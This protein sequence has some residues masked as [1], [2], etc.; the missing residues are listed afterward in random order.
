MK[1]HQQGARGV[2]HIGD[3]RAGQVPNQPRVNVAECQ[4]P[5]FGFG[6]RAF[7]IIKDPFYFRARK[8]SGKRQACFFAQTILSAVFCQLI[9]NHIGAGV[10]P[11][12]CIVD[13]LA[14]GF[15]PDNR[16]LALICNSNRDDITNFRLL[17]FD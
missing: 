1:I 2:G 15:I 6:A 16:R 3:M 5:F 9:A 13:R 7:H 4:F 17:I 10:L 14:R 11:D 8:I 12:N